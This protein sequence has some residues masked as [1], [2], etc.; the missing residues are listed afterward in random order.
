[1]FPLGAYYLL[2][3]CDDYV[4][5]GHS[6]FGGFISVSISILDPFD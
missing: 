4:R 2:C 6:V 3:K 1:M 5:D